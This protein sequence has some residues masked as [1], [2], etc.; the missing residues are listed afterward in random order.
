MLGHG[1]IA[2]PAVLLP[3]NEV[4]SLCPH[5][6]A[7]PWPELHG[8]AHAERFRGRSQ[9][10]EGCHWA[11]F[12]AERGCRALRDRMLSRERPPLEGVGRHW[13][14]QGRQVRF[15]AALL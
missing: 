3:S 1:K 2:E 7:P 10:R 6:A 9:A 4:V 13:R 5:P 11:R 15:V 12:E 8:A 14:S